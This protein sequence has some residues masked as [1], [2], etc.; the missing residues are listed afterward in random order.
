MVLAVLILAAGYPLGGFIGDRL[1]KRTPRGRLIVASL[2]VAAGAALMYLTLN[3]PLG[4]EPLFL[5]MLSASALFIPFASA[6]VL[7]TVYDVTLPEV[8]STANAVQSFIEQGGSAVAPTLAGLIAVNSS[9]KDAILVICLSTWV[10]CF[11]FFL[12][13]IYTVPRDILHLRTQL[14][15]RA[16]VEAARQVP[17]YTQYDNG[18]ALPNG[19]GAV[20]GSSRRGENLYNKWVTG[21]KLPRFGTA[22][23]V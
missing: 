11:V 5:G 12:G 16:D 21:T 2:G 10:L 23:W 13:A 19:R 9:L 8:R 14:R 7:S 20:R 22:A 18:D 4:N 6:N 1:F 17:V 3:V 15:E